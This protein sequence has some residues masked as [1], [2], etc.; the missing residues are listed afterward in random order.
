MFVITE[1]IIKRPVCVVSRKS[2]L[3]LEGIMADDC[4]ETFL[5]DKSHVEEL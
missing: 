1:N 5:E 2:S 4:N 3:L